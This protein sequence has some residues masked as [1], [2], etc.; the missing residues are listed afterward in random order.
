MDNYDN[1]F[2]SNFLQVILKTN[3]ELIVYLFF[4]KEKSSPNNKIMKK[5]TDTIN[6]SN[7]LK[8]LIDLDPLFNIELI[9][10]ILLFQLVNEYWK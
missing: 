2:S 3:I 10:K 9:R 7:A 1:S 4:L 5:I 8:I 6:N